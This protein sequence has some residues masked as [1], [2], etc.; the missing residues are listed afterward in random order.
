MARGRLPPKRNRQHDCPVEGLWR[1]QN[2][3]G[4]LG[5]KRQ[6]ML[7]PAPSPI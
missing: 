4:R 6:N 7:R 1:L 3:Q 2:A 5:S